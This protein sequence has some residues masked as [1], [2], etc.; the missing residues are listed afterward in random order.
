MAHF[1]YLKA[2]R[3]YNELYY[4]YPKAFIESDYYSKMSEGAKIAYMLLKARSELAIYRNQIDEDGN[5]YFEFT[6]KELSLMMNCSERRITGI[7]KELEEHNL[8]K[9]KRMGFNSATGKNEKNRLYLAELEV[10]EKDIYSM[11]KR[12]QILDNSGLANFATRSEENQIAQTLD[13]SGLANSATR[14]EDAQSLNNNGLANSAKVFNNNPDT[15]R[16]LIDTDKDELQNQILLDNFVTSCHTSQVPTFIPDKVLQL[17]STFS[18]NVE[19]ASQTVKTI[20]N[21][22]Y[23]AQEQTGITI[24]FEEL[25]Q[26]GINAEEGLYQTLLK[27]YQKNKT[28]KVKDIQNLIFVYVRNWFIEKPIALIQQGQNEESLPDVSIDSW[29]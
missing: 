4:Q 29:L 25:E 1:N 10:T 12:A 5:L 22:K 27:A 17:I 6:G 19:I 3:T 13:N 2:N 16:H 28:E 24:V 15:N 23:K 9:Q 18:P 8:L 20:H 11:Q 14:S 26:Q 21:A 7:K